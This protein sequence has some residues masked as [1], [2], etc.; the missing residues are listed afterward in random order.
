[1]S[2]PVAGVR[3]RDSLDSPVGDTNSYIDTRKDTPHEYTLLILSSTPGI[4]SHVWRL[5][6]KS[7]AKWA[8]LTQLIRGH[9]CTQTLSVQEDRPRTRCRWPS[10]LAHAPKAHTYLTRCKFRNWKVVP[11]LHSPIQD[12]EPESSSKISLAG[13]QFSS[14]AGAVH[15]KEDPIPQGGKGRWRWTKRRRTTMRRRTR[16]RTE[17]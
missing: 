7:G 15:K 2:Q 17:R 6:W 10:S 13:Y 11:L 3:R 4:L 12:T 14:F 1:M 5:L 8:G 9:A 16:C